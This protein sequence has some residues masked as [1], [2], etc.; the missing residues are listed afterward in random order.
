MGQVLSSYG[1]AMPYR[2]GELLETSLGPSS[3]TGTI[4][5]SILLSETSVPHIYL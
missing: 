4:L 3:D 5:R 2:F 1:L